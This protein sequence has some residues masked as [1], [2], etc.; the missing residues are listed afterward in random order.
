MARSPTTHFADPISDPISDPIPF[1]DFGI[2][3]CCCK[4]LLCL[5]LGFFLP[6]PGDLGPN[7]H[8]FFSVIAQLLPVV[9]KLDI[10]AAAIKIAVNS[11]G[12]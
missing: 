12:T 6:I 7:P 4:L 9:L 1:G 3:C 5:V 8:K 2:V 10:C 11:H